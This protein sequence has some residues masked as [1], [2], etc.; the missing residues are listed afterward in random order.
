MCPNKSLEKSQ[1]GM[2]DFYLFRKTIDEAKDFVHDINIHHRGEALLHKRLFDMIRYAKKR[3][4]MLKLHT[5]AT[6]L[7]EK[8][9]K[10][11]LES[12]LDFISFSFDGLD[13][14][15]YER[16][17]VGAQYEIT[18]K[19][20]KDFLRL[21]KAHKKKKP[22]TVLELIDYE[23]HDSQYDLK[24]LSEFK[25]Q[26]DEL[27]L[28]KLV[29]KKPH[30]FGGNVELNS[31]GG[32]N[33]Y[34]PCTYLWHSLVVLWNGDILPCTQDFNGELVLGNLKDKSLE[35]IFYGDKLTSLR[36]KALTGDLEKLHPCSHCDMIKRKR[37]I[38]VPVVSFR[39]LQK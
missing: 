32:A 2:M 39:Y 11:L 28:D 36:Q 16:Y 20:I 26:F 24:K 10:G 12:G 15:T 17:R 5:N 1:L 6:I 25:R 9:A 27:S 21:K 37:I 33:A 30:N 22:F 14:E 8:N 31:T 38:G 4:V 3:D 34:S 13:K 35:E 18:V 29:V 7:N 19:N 23:K